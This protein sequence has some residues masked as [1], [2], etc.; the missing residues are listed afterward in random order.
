MT[1]PT[2]PKARKERPIVSGV[3]DYFPDALAAVAYVSFIGNKQH[4]PG[5]PMHWAREKSND[6]ADC[7]AR[8]L[9]ERGTD[10]DDGLSH[11]SKLA[12]RALALLQIEIE[13]QADSER[14][15]RTIDKV[16]EKI[17]KHP[18]FRSVDPA[19]EVIDAIQQPV[20]IEHPPVY[21]QGHPVPFVEKLSGP[22]GIKGTD[23]SPGEVRV[24][25]METSNK[26]VYVAGPMRGYEFCNFPAFDAARDYLDQE[27]WDVISPADIDREWGLDAI[28]DPE[29]CSAIMDAWTP[30]EL[31]AV[32]KR[33]AMELLSLRKER[34]DAIALLPNWESSTGAVAEFFLARWCGLLV[35]DARTGR[36]LCAEDVDYNDLN[37]TIFR[38]LTDQEVVL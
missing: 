25:D 17:A 34:G 15:Q 9:L 36:T 26:K 7:I 35:L 24:V 18:A 4:N 28:V 5:E 37:G 3:L 32:I 13:E 30:E 8:H 21:Y 22:L 6:H 11:S 19:S 38:F 20:P 31:R 29:G 23:P 14:V 1:L 10:D 27:G 2:D 16:K 12:W 33:D